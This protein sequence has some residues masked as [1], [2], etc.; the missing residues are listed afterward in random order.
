MK[1]FSDYPWAAPLKANES[2]FKKWEQEKTEKSFL[3]WCL[4]TKVINRKD[5]FAWASEFYNTPVLESGFFEQNFMDKSQWKRVNDLR[6]WRMD[7]LPV[8]E[9]EGAVFVGC[10]EPP[11]D[12]EAWPFKRRIILVSDSAL[13]M[14]WKMMRQCLASGER[15]AAAANQGKINQG[16]IKTLGSPSA[17]QPLNSPPHIKGRM[18]APDG[19]GFSM[20]RLLGR[21]A[22]GKEAKRD[23]KEENRAKNIFQMGYALI[24]N[25]VTGTDFKIPES[26]G[27]PLPEQDP[28]PAE[29][30]PAAKAAEKPA[31]HLQVVQPSKADPAPQ[32]KASSLEGS[33]FPAPE[34]VRQHADHGK[35]GLGREGEV[36]EGHIGGPMAEKMPAPAA[37][38][39]A[40]F[41]P[42][43]NRA[44]ILKNC[45]EDGEVFSQL[46]SEMK[47]RFTACMVLANKGGDLFPLEWTGLVGHW[48][49]SLPLINLTDQSLFKVAGRGFPYHGFVVAT[50]ANKRF[51][52]KIG[53][54]Q[55][56]KY[57][58][59][60]PIKSESKKIEYVFFGI[61][62]KTISDRQIIK[63][64]EEMAISFFSALKEKKK[65]AA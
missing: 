35:T 8:W 32:K 25:Q 23:Q 3:F 47:P 49:K 21:Q 37:L 64:T 24:K 13:Q 33:F 1:L 36:R 38:L 56:P 65:Q 58:T 19:G 12:H 31:S 45:H 9:W 7:M 54:N 20:E 53:W 42:D 46:W 26:A 55:L 4:N 40:S 62:N 30:A 63:K 43:K 27:Q 59:A 18:A 51:F 52:K 17:A 10:L 15:S 50:E 11:G 61:S 57:A 29:S 22:K 28:S 44:Y 41:S 14:N 5:Y 60:I 39:E 6:E 16:K 48:D 2:C 34:E